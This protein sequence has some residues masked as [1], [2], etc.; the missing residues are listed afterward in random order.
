MVSHNPLH[1]S[2]RAAFPHPALASGD[3]AEAPE[4]IRMTDA[5]S[6]QPAANQSQHSVPPHSAILAA[7]RE[8]TIPESSDSEPKQGERRAVHRD[9]VITDVSLD[10]RAQPSA[11]YRDRVVHAQLE[12]VPAWLDTLPA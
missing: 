8:R 5:R 11:H 12:F 6:G 4:R 7:T 2:G 9:T 3:D 10:H 1:R